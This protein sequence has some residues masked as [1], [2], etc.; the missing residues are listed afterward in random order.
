MP[1][2]IIERNVPGAS[3]LTRQELR[4]LSS[5][6]NSVVAGLGV[7]YTWITSYVAGDMIY[8]VHEADSADV[9]IRHAETAGFPLDK[10]TEI[11]SIIGP[12]TAEGVMAEAV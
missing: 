5:K 10:V 8:C 4:D 2:Y 7:P 9:I 11:A 1:K 12:Q 6:S 3:R